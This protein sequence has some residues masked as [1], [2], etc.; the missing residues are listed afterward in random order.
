[1]PVL[2]FVHKRL[3]NKFVYQYATFIWRQHLKLF[4]WNV[5][6]AKCLSIRLE[7]AVS[8]LS[9]TIFLNFVEVSFCDAFIRIFLVL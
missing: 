2:R 8:R 3:L 7:A 4:S 5:K 9:V 1:M 6:F